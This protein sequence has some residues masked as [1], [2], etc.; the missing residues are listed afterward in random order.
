M[1]SKKVLYKTAVLV[2][3]ISIS[4]FF[5]VSTMWAAGK[6]ESHRQNPGTQVIPFSIWVEAPVSKNDIRIIVENKAPKGFEPYRGPNKY[7]RVLTNIDM[8]GLD[9]NGRRKQIGKD[10]KADIYIE[11]I[12]S[13][14]DIERVGKL[15]NLQVLFWI[16]NLNKWK[17]YNELE[18]DGEIKKVESTAKNSF[19]FKILRWPL[20]D[21]Y[22]AYGG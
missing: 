10:F 3:L 5:T 7:F 14:Y 4:L 6:S 1:K 9:N 20:N 2:V 8:Y 22:I 12:Y 18:K 19:R 21:R 17:N 16:P 11:V 13:K 15:D